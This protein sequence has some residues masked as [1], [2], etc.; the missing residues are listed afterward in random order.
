MPI[1]LA[2]TGCEPIVLEMNEISVGSAQNCGVSFLN[3]P[4]VKPKHAVIRM[5]AGRWLVEVREA[6]AIYVNTDEPKRM[7]WLQPGDVIRL[8]LAGPEI[9]FQPTGIAHV[10]TPAAPPTTSWRTVAE[11]HEGPRPSSDQIRSQPAPSN[12]PVQA[13][14][15]YSNHR[16]PIGGTPAPD[17]IDLPDTREF[18]GYKV[19]PPT[20]IDS[21]RPITDASASNSAWTES[22]SSHAVSEILSDQPPAEDDA[23]F[24]K[25]LSYDESDQIIDLDQRDSAAQ[26][27]MQWIWTIV[28]RCVLTGVGFLIVWLIVMEVIKLTR[29]Q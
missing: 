15:V 3:M 22:V 16:T 20:T 2:V 23:A 4:N 24:L 21:A 29:G 11:T 5:I 19:E 28:I 26:S 9:I 27:E 25:R 6:D 12:K 14:S 18:V 8:T 13:T 17:D 7:Q 1:K 10:P